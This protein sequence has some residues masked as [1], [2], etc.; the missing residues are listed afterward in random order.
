M[1]LLYLLLYI[2]YSLFVFIFASHCMKSIQTLSTT[3]C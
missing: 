2:V 1:S 3:T